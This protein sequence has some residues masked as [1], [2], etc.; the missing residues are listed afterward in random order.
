MK[1]INIYY[2]L[3]LLFAVSFAACEDTN[4][5]LV[6]ERGAAVVPKIS[7]IGPGFYT[8]DFEN[9][10]IKFDVAIPEGQKVDDAEIQATFKDKTTVIEKIT[11][12]PTT[13]QIT[14]SDV[15]SKMGLSDNDVELGDSFIIDV[16]TTF[17][18]VTTRS[19]TGS[20]KASVTCELF[21]DDFVGTHIVSLDEWDGGG[22]QVEVK[23]ISETELSVEG[24]FDGY[25]DNPMI[26]KINP[27]DHSITVPKQML[28]ANPTAWWGS[29]SPYLD[30]SLAGVGTL[31]ACE[32][33]L[34]FSAEATV[35]AGSFGG[36][37]KFKIGKEKDS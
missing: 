6:K 3:A 30:F 18:G 34:S 14:A 5:N 15:I 1:K 28:V 37:I 21:I 25:A 24:M 27:I 2:I 8:T 23:K 9:S 20:I 7:N 31:D 33:S 36:G 12:F 10:Y 17:E 35:D 26:I 19:Y 22:Y 13:I 4:E 16:V 32:I 11:S 29:P